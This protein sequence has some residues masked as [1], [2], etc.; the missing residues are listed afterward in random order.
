MAAKRKRKM[1]IV[2]GR[3]SFPIDMLRHD[4]CWPYTSSDASQIEHASD[5]RRVALLTDNPVYPTVGRW[6]SFLWS[7]VEERNL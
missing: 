2:E 6:N 5:R 4:S 7:V 3:G 1:F